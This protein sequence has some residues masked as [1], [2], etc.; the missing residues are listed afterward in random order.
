MQHIG[1]VSHHL[2]QCVSGDLG[3]TRIY[4]PDIGIQPC[5][6]NR[7]RALI[8]GGIKGTQLIFLLPAFF[9]PAR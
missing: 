6:H 7:G 3:K 4:I 8:D 2:M 9:Q 5:D 1:I